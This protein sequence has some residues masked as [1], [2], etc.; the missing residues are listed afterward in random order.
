MHR[1]LF[2]RECSEKI[3]KKWKNRIGQKE[4]QDYIMFA[5]G[6]QKIP[7]RA[8]ELGCSFLLVPN[9]VSDW[10]F[11]FSHQPVIDCGVSPGR[12]CN[13]GR[14]SLPQSRPFSI[15]L[16]DDVSSNLGL[17]M[18]ALKWGLARNTIVSTVS[19]WIPWPNRLSRLS[20]CSQQGCC[21][22]FS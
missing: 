21:Q 19:W 15:R 16:A 13:L 14:S 4:N 20:V 17:N 12:G 7:C 10:G 8:L 18:L 9:C 2:F 22:E 1:K 11:V 5:T 3:Q 6:P